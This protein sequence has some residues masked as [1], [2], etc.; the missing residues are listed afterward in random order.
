MVSR[1]SDGMGVGAAISRSLRVRDPGNVSSWTGGLQDPLLGEVRRLGTLLEQERSELQVSVWET[2]SLRSSGDSW[3]CGR[4]W[5][6]SQNAAVLSAFNLG[7][8]IHGDY[9]H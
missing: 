7:V 4:E 6:P 9:R 5:E 8:N 2:R 3:S 1:T